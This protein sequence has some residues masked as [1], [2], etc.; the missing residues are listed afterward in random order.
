[1][2]RC[3]EFKGLY[4]PALIEVY[5]PTDATTLV[6]RFDEQPTN[7]AGMSGVEPCSTVLATHTVARIQGTSDTPPNCFWADG[8]TLVAYLTMF[9]NAG[10]GMEIVVKPNVLWPLTWSYPGSCHGVD[11]MCA[12]ADGE[13]VSM[14]VDEFFL[15]DR[16]FTDELET[17]VQPVSLIQAP[18]KLSSCPGTLI[19]LRRFPQHWWWHQAP[20]VPMGSASYQK[21]QLLS[22]PTKPRN[23][24]WQRRRQSRI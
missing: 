4:K 3:F 16:K 22:D 9:T 24:R 14:S 19:Q 5:F 2:M 10:P 15:C 7:K 6:I 13:T 18:E 17:C 23:A 12:G 21:R 1:M 20:H 11:S 8:S